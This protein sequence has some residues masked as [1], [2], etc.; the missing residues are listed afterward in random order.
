MCLD[1][2]S[3]QVSLGD[4]HVQHFMLRCKETI[5]ELEKAVQEGYFILAKFLT[6]IML[7]CHNLEAML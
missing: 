5:Y 3:Q 1:A 6:D 2:C 4:E 7:V